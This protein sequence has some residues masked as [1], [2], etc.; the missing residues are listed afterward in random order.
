MTFAATEKRK[1][2]RRKQM[3]ELERDAKINE[4]SSEI[5]DLALSGATPDELKDAIAHSMEV[6]DSLK[7]LK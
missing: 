1:N 6:L 2:I 5:A 3:N 7:K 4:L